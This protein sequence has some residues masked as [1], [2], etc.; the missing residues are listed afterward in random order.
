MIKKRFFLLFFTKN[1]PNKRHKPQNPRPAK[2]EIDDKNK[3]FVFMS[4]DKSDN[5]WQK[6]QPN[7]TKNTQNKRHK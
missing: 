7:T 1:R 2:K 5:T 3:P 6:I 4:A